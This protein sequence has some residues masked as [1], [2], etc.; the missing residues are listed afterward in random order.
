MPSSRRKIRA[1]AFGAGSATAPVN[2]SDKDSPEIPAATSVPPPST[3]EKAQRFLVR[4]RTFFTLVI[5]LAMVTAARPRPDWLPAGIALCLAG[6][7][8]RVWAAG[9]LIKGTQLITS[10]PFAHLRHPLYLGSLLITTGYCV[11]TG[12]WISFP[13]VWALYGLF[14][15]SAMFSEERVLEAAFG[16]KYRTYK[17]RTPLLVPRLSP[18]PGAPGRFSYHRFKTNRE[19]RVALGV[20]IVVALFLVRHVSV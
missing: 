20:V 11:L 9:H 12:L 19:P 16:A 6:E 8:V 13:V 3:W 14:F 1:V 15:L 5:P 17:A 7:V 4:R 10:G 18:F 2:G